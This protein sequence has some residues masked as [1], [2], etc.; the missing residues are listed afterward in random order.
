MQ[1]IFTGNLGI[2]MVSIMMTIWMIKIHQ[3]RRIEEEEWNRQWT[4]YL[5]GNGNSNDTDNHTTL[6]ENENNNGE[7]LLGAGTDFSHMSFQMQLALAMMESQRIMQM[8]M[9]NG[10]MPV[11]SDRNGESAGVSREIMDGWTRFPYQSAPLSSEGGGI[12]AVGASPETP[13]NN[14]NKTKMS[15]LDKLKAKGR[16]YDSLIEE[17]DDAVELHDLTLEEEE[18]MEHG[19]PTTIATTPQPQKTMSEEQGE[20]DAQT[21]SICLCEYEQGEEIVRLPCGHVYHDSCISVWVQNHVRCPLCN[22]NLVE[23]DDDAETPHE[24]HI[25]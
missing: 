15:L 19:Q 3:Q 11:N 18:R 7:W 22:F 4:D 21:C 12:L 5:H 23:E 10:G 8:S 24:N 14:K 6:D 16:K 13:D 17:D 2:M 9:R 25:V 20:G 1:A